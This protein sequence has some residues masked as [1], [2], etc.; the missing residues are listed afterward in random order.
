MSK[1]LFEALGPEESKKA[2]LHFP[3]NTFPGQ[4]KPLKDDTHF[5]RYGGYE[6]AKCV[7]EGIKSNHLDLA[8][9]LVEDVPPFNPATPDPIAP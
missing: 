5:S 4:D 2:L 9:F 7:V 1:T 3:A 6:L 8:K